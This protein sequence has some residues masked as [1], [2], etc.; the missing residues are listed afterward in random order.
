MVTE[1][2]TLQNHNRFAKPHTISKAK[3]ERAAEKACERLANMAKA[4]YGLFPSNWSTDFLYKWDRNSNWVSGMYTGCFWLAYQL[5][6]DEFFRQVA[7]SHLDSYKVRLDERRGILGHDVGFPYMP[8]CAAAYMVTGNEYAKKIALDTAEFFYGNGYEQRAKFKYIKTTKH[9]S[10][11][12][13]MMNAFLFLWAGKETGDKKFD[14]AGLNQF[15]TTNEF[16]IRSDASSFHHYQFDP[17]TA[18]PVRGKTL[19]GNSD[20]SCWSRGHSWGVYAMAGA[21]DYT[22]EPFLVQLQKDI[23]Y[24]AL[25]HLP[26][27]LIPYWDYDFTSGDEARDTSAGLI[28]ACGMH[29]MAKHLPT[30]A[31]QKPIYESA[32]AQMVESIIDN[33]TEGFPTDDGLVLRVTASKPHGYGVD[34]VGVYGDFFYLEALARYI[35][36]DKFIRYW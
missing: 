4:H 32:A 1:K 3:L 6:G 28:T 9:V 26:E 16:L 11:M 5:T 30:D 27:D 35:L 31:E 29:E 34:Q 7:E 15:I 13:T 22:H 2:I 24:F 36:G 21:Y 25:N 12:D 14:V 20:D 33:C 17:E 10:M 18:L 23:T 19:Q 8:S